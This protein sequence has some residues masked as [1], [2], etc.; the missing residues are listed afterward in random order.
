MSNSKTYVQINVFIFILF[1]FG[2]WGES[3]FFLLLLMSNIT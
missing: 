2:S 3:A 1:A